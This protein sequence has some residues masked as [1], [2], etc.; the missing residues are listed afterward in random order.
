MLQTL[1]KDILIKLIS[2]IEVETTCKFED[3]LNEL[4][5]KL[6]AWESSEGRNMICKCLCVINSKIPCKG[7]GHINKNRCD[8]CDIV[9][10]DV[11]LYYRASTLYQSSSYICEACHSQKGK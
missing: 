8:E 6:D 7:Y 5:N 4:E 10:C 9:C 11:H 1:P 3:K 2:M